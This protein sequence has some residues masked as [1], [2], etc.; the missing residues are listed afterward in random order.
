MGSPA[1]SDAPL[2]TH[3]APD[4]GYKAVVCDGE[5]GLVVGQVGV[6]VVEAGGKAGSASE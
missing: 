1:E 4:P 6:E 3:H 5:D 2:D